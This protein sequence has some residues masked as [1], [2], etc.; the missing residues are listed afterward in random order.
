[1]KYNLGEV[2]VNRQSGAAADL[3]SADT[4]RWSA[5][6]KA[7]VV[8]AVRDRNLRR[9]GFAHHP[10]ADLSR[11]ASVGE[12]PQLSFLVA[13]SGDAASALKQAQAGAIDDIKKAG[14]TRRAIK[15]AA[16]VKTT[17]TILRHWM[18]PHCDSPAWSSGSQQILRWREYL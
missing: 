10:A 6:R 13:A 8:S 2:T 17:R 15:R 16:R 5:R 14:F 18:R 3:P 11:H 1:M 7:A 4:K 12:P 9:R